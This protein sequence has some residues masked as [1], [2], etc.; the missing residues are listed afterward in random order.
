MKAFN[1]VNRMEL[2]AICTAFE[3]DIKKFILDSNNKIPFTEEMEDKAHSREKKAESN[4][5]ILD[6]LDLGDY[7]S[8]IVE[9]AYTFGINLDKARKIKKYFEKI[10]PVR[11]R[12]MHTKPLE[13]GDRSLILEILDSIDGEISWIEW[14]ELKIIKKT[15]KENPNDLISNSYIPTKEITR[16][17]HN[18][19]E[20]EFDDTGYIGREKDRKEIKELI[21]NNKN[22]IITIVGN[23]GV[24]KTALVV[25]VLYDLIDNPNCY[26]DC[27]LWISLKTNTLSIGEFVQIK[28]NISSIP[29]IYSFA[30]KEIG[31]QK[32]EKSPKEF[33]LEFM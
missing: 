4:R 23:G 5:E 18:L 12:V 30:V 21:L 29:E 3:Y 6:Q 8:L 16:I 15:V 19:P 7:I 1:I 17:Y 22:Q 10:I 28:N 14:N 20:A 27:I 33:L 31:D 13:L 24:G 26:F 2:F 32:L 11:N 25:K 9:N